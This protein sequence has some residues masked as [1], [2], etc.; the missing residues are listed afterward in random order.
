MKRWI[1]TR[2]LKPEREFY[3]T[4]IDLLPMSRIAKEV[5]T[6]D[7]E[8]EIRRNRGL[9]RESERIRKER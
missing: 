3:L 7:T 9:M 2:E 5:V 8:R 6:K 1:K 4:H